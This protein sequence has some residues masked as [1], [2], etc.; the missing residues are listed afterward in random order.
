MCW[1]AALFALT[2]TVVVPEPVKVIFD[3]DM[4]TD[5]DDIG[6]LAMLHAMADAGEADLLAVLQNTRGNSGLA[7]VEIINRYYGRP[8]LPVG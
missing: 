7:V 5:Y 4:Y 6:A 3:T 2:I 8:D 1:A